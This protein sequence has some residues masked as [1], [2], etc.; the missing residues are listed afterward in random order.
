MKKQ[1]LIVFL[2]LSLLLCFF[3]F[4]SICFSGAKGG[5]TLWFYTII[6]SLLP[7]LIVS[8]LILH[9][10]LLPYL[11]PILAP[12]FQK[13]FSVSKAGCYPILIG[14][15]SGY[16]MGAKACADLVR[17]G[18]ISKKEGQ[19]IL[20][21]V[22]NASPMFIT[23]F[24]ATQC[25]ELPSMQYIFYGLILGSAYLCSLIFGLFLRKKVSKTSESITETNIIEHTNNLSFATALDAS[26]LDAFTT[27][28]KIGGFII[29][30]SILGEFVLALPFHLGF[31]RYL[32]L[33]I[34]EIT[35]ANHF[36][37]LSTYS[38]NIKIILN[39]ATTTFG[40]L[41]GLFQTQSVIAGSGLSLTYYIF[42]KLLQSLL[43]VFGTILLLIFIT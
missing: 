14:L 1:K 13:I 9:L 32:L 5:L 22:N 38:M 16:P 35:T 15:L 41:S 8:N 36:I 42:M 21:F 27:I 10:N 18:D 23:S 30:F 19:Y 12:F 7:F 26:I 24:V 28:T 3:F 25:L 29:L 2:L 11:T 4:P 34:L 17:K 37:S 31:L 40:G 6:P 43:V 33:C 39:L 20:S